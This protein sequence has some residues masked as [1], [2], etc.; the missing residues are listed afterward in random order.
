M[1]N[2]VQRLHIAII[3][4]YLGETQVPLT[5]WRITGTNRRRS[6]DS[7]HEEYTQTCPPR[8]GGQRSPLVVAGF[9]MTASQS[10]P[11]SKPRKC[12]RH[13]HCVSQCSCGCGSV[14]TGKTPDCETQRRSSSKADLVGESAAITGPYSKQLSANRVGGPCGRKSCITFLRE[15]ILGL[16]H[17]VI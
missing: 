11:Q 7:P 8:Q 5:G 3:G 9:S 14:K 6:L 15:A 16:C 2:S 12:S 10:V 1:S 17:F 13:T 4:F